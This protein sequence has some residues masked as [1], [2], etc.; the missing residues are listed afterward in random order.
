[1]ELTLTSTAYLQG[2]VKKTQHT[3]AFKADP[4]VENHAVSLYP[5]VQYQEIMGFG[6]AVT[7]AAGY[8]FSRMSREKQQEIL[9]AYFGPD[10]NQYTM[11]RVSID[12]CDFALGNYSAVTDP[13]DEAFATFTLKRDEQYV[14]PLLHRAQEAAKTKLNLMLSPWSP[15]AFMKSNGQKNGGGYLLPEYYG[16][17][18]DYI[19]RYIKE[20]QA[21]GYNVTMITVQN[22]PKA[23]QTWDSCIYT[24]EEEKAFLRD[25]LYPALEKNSLADVGIYIWDHNKERVYERARDI[26]DEKTVK[27]VKGVAFHWYS[28]EHFEAVRLVSEQFPDKKLV[29]SEGCVEYSRFGADDQLSHARM[30][31]HDIIGN[32]KAGM[33][34]YLDWNILLNEKG[35]PNHV[36]NFCEAPLMCDPEKNT[37]ERKLSFEYIGHFSRFIKPGAIRIASSAYTDKLDTVS[38]INPDGTL[39]SVYLNKTGRALPVVIRLNGQVASFTLAA[40]AIATGVIDKLR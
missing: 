14:L 17:W 5:G 22:E 37:V 19:C 8:V 10:G 21:R 11:A 26:I 7:E 6:G 28:G 2:K 32:L 25:F 12:S 13:K 30:Y 27:M 4:G 24:A 40:N 9:D 18:A 31:A 3:A 38:F 33:H 36:G 23:V 1:M 16:Q 15:P 20:Y 29:F 35:G 34:G 39:V